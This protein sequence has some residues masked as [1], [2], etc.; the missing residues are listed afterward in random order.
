[1][2]GLVDMQTPLY[3]AR[4]VGAQTTLYAEP[5]RTSAAIADLPSGEE[6][7]ITDQLTSEGETWVAVA[8]PGECCGYLPSGTRIERCPIVELAGD[9]AIRAEPSEDSAVLVLYGFGARL[10]VLGDVMQDGRTWLRVADG[11]RRIGFMPV[12]TQ[13]EDTSAESAAQ[14]LIAKGKRDMVVG[15]LWCGGGIVVTL[16]TYAAASGG[17]TYVV[18]WGAILFGGIQFLRGVAHYLGAGE[19]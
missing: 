7:W 9:A 6:L 8:L 3:M 1:M 13:L 14:A 18:A 19:S 2:A 15:G 16:Y 12:E 4:L 5:Y 10:W 11:E 17:G